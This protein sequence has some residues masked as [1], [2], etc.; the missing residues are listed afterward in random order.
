MTRE[1]QRST[2]QFDER[3]RDAQTEAGAIKT[4]PAGL[5]CLLERCENA[6]MI[7]RVNPNSAVFH[8]NRHPTLSRQVR[9]FPA[10]HDSHKTALSELDGIAYQIVKNLSQPNGIAAHHLRQVRRTDKFEGQP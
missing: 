8:G 10:G 4:T 7:G 9:G 1:L 6:L 5:P 3:A 2:L